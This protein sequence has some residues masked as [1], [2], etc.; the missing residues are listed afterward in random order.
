MARETRK[1]V[2]TDPNS[3]DRNKMFILR[4]MPAAVAEWW[5]IRALIVMGNS[6]VQM[7]TGVMESGL[8]GL[9]AMERMKGTASALFAIGLRIL[10]GVNARELKPLLDE[11]MECVTYQPPGNFPAQAILEGEM[12]QIEEVSTILRLRAEVLE[13][14]LGFSLAGAASTL[15]TTP[16]ESAPA[17]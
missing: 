10:P 2:I 16:P 13:L 12:S 17:S 7:P 8:A 3:R 4:E 1:V 6:G 5:A 11:M 14:H 15:D 9:A